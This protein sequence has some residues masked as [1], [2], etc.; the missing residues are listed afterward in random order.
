M[1]P[2]KRFTDAVM[3]SCISIRWVMNCRFL[4]PPSRPLM[5]NFRSCLRKVV[6]MMVFLPPSLIVVAKSTIFYAL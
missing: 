2:K 5:L 4:T 3:V 6:V 1:M